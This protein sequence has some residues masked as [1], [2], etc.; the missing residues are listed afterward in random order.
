MLNVGLNS[1]GTVTWRSLQGLNCVYILSC[2]HPTSTSCSL[3]QEEATGEGGHSKAGKRGSVGLQGA[4]GLSRG[5]REF[6]HQMIMEPGPASVPGLRDP[7]EDKKPRGP[8]L[9][10]SLAEQTDS[11]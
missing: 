9:G 3:W 10:F 2:L 11:R 8:H 1:T 7:A 6:S 4:L 5:S